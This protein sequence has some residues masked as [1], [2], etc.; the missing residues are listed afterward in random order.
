MS[1]LQLVLAVL[2]AA[3]LAAASSARAQDRLTV[4]PVPVHPAVSVP[5]IHYHAVVADVEDDTVTLDVNGVSIQ[6]PLCRLLVRE[7]GRPATSPLSVG[8]VVNVTQPP[9]T[10]T[11]A[12]V[13]AGVMCLVTSQG[14]VELPVQ[15]LPAPVMARLRV[16]VKQADGR[17]GRMSMQQAMDCGAT[18]FAPAGLD[19]TAT[20]D[21]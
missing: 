9:V 10:G 13:W 1:R 19:A 14:R 6:V 2:V 4:L 16:W 11:V 20:L 7:R 3:F 12:T 18:M 17:L 21:R 15:A 5:T 8:D